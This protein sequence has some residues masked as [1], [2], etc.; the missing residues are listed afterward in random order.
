MAFETDSSSSRPRPRRSPRVCCSLSESVSNTA[1]Q[2]TCASPRTAV[3][4]ARTTPSD[5]LL[6][7]LGRTRRPFFTDGSAA[8]RHSED[9][10]AAAPRIDSRL[11]AAVAWLDD[12][13]EPIAETNRRI[14]FVARDL[15][16][17]KPSY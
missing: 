16:L 8:R 12:R 7:G 11:V 15:G 2:C 9:L 13:R 10:T 17:T 5:S 6:L 3:A 1:G 4:Q 14:G